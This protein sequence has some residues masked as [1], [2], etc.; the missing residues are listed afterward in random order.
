MKPNSK[1]WFDNEALN[2]TWNRSKHYKKVKQSGNESDKDN[3]KH[4]RLLPKNT[5]TENFTLKRKM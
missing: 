5:I 3:F 1:P 4:S 2:A